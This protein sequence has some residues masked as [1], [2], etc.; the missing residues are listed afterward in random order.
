MSRNSF[1]TPMEDV[2][3]FFHPLGLLAPVAFLSQ[4]QW[5][6]SIGPPGHGLAFKYIPPNSRM[7][8]VE[9]RMVGWMSQ[10]KPCKS[11]C[12]QLAA[13]TISYMAC[14]LQ[15]PDATSWNPR[16]QF[17]MHELLE[18][19]RDVG[20]QFWLCRHVE[21]LTRPNTMF[22]EKQKLPNTAS[23]YVTSFPLIGK[24]EIRDLMSCI[25]LDTGR[26]MERII[27][28]NSRSTCKWFL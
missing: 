19:M 22:S 4:F 12:T 18:L 11:S 26:L 5:H 10:E 17:E 6:R 2:W 15:G 1:S 9:N 3:V 28:G 25:I 8:G 14:L 20:T 21:Y 7:I 24:Q 23:R 16:Q 13:D 27:S